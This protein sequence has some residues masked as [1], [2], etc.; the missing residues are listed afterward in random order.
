M[1]MSVRYVYGE[2]TALRVE[3][4]TTIK[5]PGRGRYMGDKAILAGYSRVVVNGTLLIGNYR[6]G[7][8]NPPLASGII[9]DRDD[10]MY[11]GERGKWVTFIKDGRLTENHRLE[12]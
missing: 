9:K 12:M 6:E 1:R 2:V 8:W 5:R 7:S 11:L 10:W 3:L 4:S